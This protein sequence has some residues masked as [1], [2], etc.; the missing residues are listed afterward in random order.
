MEGPS[1][2]GYLFGRV[3]F[4]T[5]SE[6][7]SK[8]RMLYGGNSKSA[9]EV[10][11][12]WHHNTICTWTHSWQS[13]QSG[14]NLRRID[15]AGQRVWGMPRDQEQGP[16]LQKV[17]FFTANRDV[18][19]TWERIAFSR[20]YNCGTTSVYGRALFRRRHIL[21]AWRIRH[22]NRNLLFWT[23]YFFDKGA[24]HFSDAL[25]LKYDMFLMKLTQKAG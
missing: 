19:I 23:D 17:N 13:M 25:F 2:V 21:L 24:W 9:G 7:I 15:S 22:M 10:T 4:G 3:I 11:L 16:K 14:L 12:W 6:E 5:R 18:L 8:I 1:E 20:A